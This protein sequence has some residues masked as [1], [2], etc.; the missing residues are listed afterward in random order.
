MLKEFLLQ[1]QPTGYEGFEG[2]IAQLLSELTELN[3]RLAKSGYQA[4][5]DLSSRDFKANVIAVETKRYTSATPLNERELLGEIA[6]ATFETPDLDL[7]IL[8]TTRD[9]DAQLY[10]K[11]NATCNDSHLQFLLISAENEP[12]NTLA[13][14]CANAPNIVLEFIADQINVDQKRLIQ[15]ELQAVVELPRYTNIRNRLKDQLLSPLV[16]YKSWQN[17]Q[18]KWFTEH[19]KNERQSRVAFGQILNVADINANLIKREKAWQ[20]FDEWWEDWTNSRH[21][22]VILGEEGDGKT[23]S[24]AAWIEQKIQENKMFPPVVFV[25]SGLARNSDI[26]QLI[27]D[28]LLHT[29][30]DYRSEQWQTRFQRWVHSSIDY[31]HPIL[32]LVLD[33]LNEQQFRA[34]WHTILESLSIEP[35][36]SKVAV[37]LTCRTGYWRQ[38][39]H[40]AMTFTK[41][42]LQPYDDH[43][44]KNALKNHKLTQS[45]IPSTLLPII[46][47]PRYFDLIVKHREKMAQSGDIT[48][49]RL[50]YED[51][52]DR[53]QRKNHLRNFNHAEFQ[54]LI[55]D[56]A[57][58]HLEKA[59]I[60]RESE[61]DHLLPVGVDS[62]TILNE[63]RTSNILHG[64]GSRLQV[65][66]QYLVYG[67]GLLLV[68]EL[69]KA[70]NNNESLE[71]TFASWLEP[72]SDM[73]IKAEICSFA[74]LHSLQLP[75]ISPSI[76]V[77]LLEEWITNRNIPS[78]LQ[79]E[80]IAYMPQNI[81]VYIELAE[82]AW[83][84]EKDHRWIQELILKGFLKWRNNKGVSTALVETAEKWLGFV[85]LHG[86]SW[87]RGQNESKVLQIH[88]KINERVSAELE[89]G[90]FWY[91][92]YKLTAT[93]DDGL[94]RLGNLALTFI[95]HLPRH[96]FMKA[97][98]I[99]N[100]AEA[101]MGYPGRYESY[102]WIFKTSN[103]SL[104]L[105]VDKEVRKLLSADTK[106][107]EK[108]AH[109]LLSYEGSSKAKIFQNTLP[110]DLF[111]KSWLQKEYEKDPCASFL[112]WNEYDISRCLLL[113][114]LSPWVKIGKVKDKIPD[115][116]FE[117]PDVFCNQLINAIRKIDGNELSSVRAMT[118]A[119]L[120]LETYEA[121][122][123]RFSPRII[124]EFT[125][126]IVRKINTREGAALAS[127]SLSLKELSMPFTEKEFE[128]VYQAWVL[129]EPNKP[130]ADDLNNDAE[131]FLFD[132][133]LEILT[134][135]H[136][137]IHILHRHPERND[138]VR[139]AIRFRP[140]DDSVSVLEAI[141][142]VH[143]VVI[144][145][146][147]LLFLIPHIRS[148]PTK[149]LEKSLQ[150]LL[151]HE[152]SYVRSLVLEI[153]YI[154]GDV[155][156]IN[157]FLESSWSWQASYHFLE[158]YWGSQIFCKYGIDFPIT[159]IFT[160]VQPTYWGI[161]IQYR[162]HDVQDMNK[163]A[164]M[165]SFLLQS[166][167][168]SSI[169]IPDDM[170]LVEIDG[171][172][173]AERD[174][175]LLHRLTISRRT[176]SDSFTFFS[177]HDTWGGVNGDFEAH[178]IALEE[179][180]SSD[181]Q[182]AR[183]ELIKKIQTEQNSS[184]N[185]IF[186]A[187]FS[188]KS[189]SQ[190]WYQHRQIIEQWLE[191][192]FSDS[193]FAHQLLHKAH[194]FYQALC[195]ILLREN[196]E[197]GV[198]L[199]N[200]LSNQ[201]GL[202]IFVDADSKIDLLDYALFNAQIAQVTKDAWR[203]RFEECTSD[204]E[205]LKLMISAQMGS[206]KEWLLDWVTQ[207][208]NSSIPLTLSRSLTLLALLD[209]EGSREKLML[210]RN[211]EPKNTWRSELVDI[212]LNRWRQNAFAKY[213]FRQYLEIENDINAWGAFRIFLTC[214]DRRYWIWR[215]QI[216]EAT[217][218]KSWHPNRVRFLSSNKNTI[219]NQISKNENKLFK[220]KLFGQKIR[221][222]QLWPW[223]L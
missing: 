168:S 173:D 150:P 146:R 204:L 92:G 85:H 151:E 51:W 145:K 42:T 120:H 88:E 45:D 23:W 199:Y 161:A 21:L 17:K 100:I 140:L 27:L 141:Q 55:R 182:K 183:S 165:L 218:E 186:L 49:A 69:E 166:V 104:W 147:T 83:S 20:K 36:C 208:C 14:L 172:L 32:L 181:W 142:S 67:L 192:I 78:D 222:R 87:Q 144:I 217:A 3:F 53:A 155:L 72:H 177:G 64:D 98:V 59:D 190:L 10:E 203:T 40:S 189:L 179:S 75:V 58:A 105:P 103:E 84:A 201:I 38:F 157:R 31:Q 47:K 39:S 124:S 102:Q 133:V 113:E 164:D 188:T 33:G 185:P 65:D 223:I 131:L 18:N 30:K 56:L 1:L 91:A 195:E 210:F 71:E 5:R 184:S 15:R 212:G 202:P 216:I 106:I 209:N 50:I 171:H 44:L 16:G 9:V 26:D 215:E 96:S 94:L 193:P 135:E 137:L 66:K 24:I 7:W 34:D 111:P 6:Q 76:C 8:V 89:P 57:S 95:S 11:L 136:Q 118:S 205:L 52:K 119:D 60:V 74:A 86:F 126:G 13:A 114:D 178:Y 152:D 73:D 170:P 29:F 112:Q 97:I 121:A 196:P 2:L 22:L 128:A 162:D 110:E 153:F 61:I 163:F 117:L 43:E 138:L 63:L 19:V 187:R 221:K 90:G 122:V 213:W 37:I 80:F 125:N 219:E 132:Q 180:L 206:A 167:A 143:D 79:Q 159:S 93:L 116:T 41:Y 101:I 48:I 99:G 191:A 77:L 82:R 107:T 25:P 214:V 123:C 156:L 148:I 70:S 134:G 194:S 109:R 160:C 35:W 54:D 115:P 198:R 154:K 169:K 127:L 4:G 220:D 62:R 108:A 139:Y 149:N 46:R 130:P 12:L 81:H 28:Q 68:D 158:N 211:Q 174:R 129:T 176:I 207:G 197:Q 175:E 200:H